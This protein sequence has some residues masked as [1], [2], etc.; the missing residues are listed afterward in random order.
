MACGGRPVQPTP[1]STVVI[2]AGDIGQCDSIGAMET[3]RLIDT[4]PGTVLAVGDI[5]YFDGSREQFRRCF[6]PVW[7]RHKQRTRPAPGNHEYQS[8]DAIPYFEYF[9]E[10]AGSE[11]VGY[12]SF[13]SGQWLML[14][15][16]SNIPV[17]RDSEQF[18]W[19]RAE[20]SAHNS[21]CALAY[22]HH[23]YISS[24]PN[25]NN[26]S[27]ANLWFLLSEFGVDI[28]VSAHDHL[29]ERLAPMMPTGQRDDARGIRQFIVG[30]GGAELTTAARA[31]PNSERIISSHGVLRLTLNP[32]G[33]EWEFVQIGGTR[34]DVGS[35]V[36]H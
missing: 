26:L 5:A 8:V 6:D 21:R 28:V 13:R 16:N 2:A 35:G 4:M 10:T 18:A 14:S 15:L 30:T 29:Y 32:D 25:G 1:T 19:L 34:A 9:A 23:P 33:Y 27:L 7:G 11:R 24:G 22:F 20:L 12:Y 31:H 36:C 17:D 3:G